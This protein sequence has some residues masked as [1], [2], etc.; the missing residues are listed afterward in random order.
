[1]H[2]SARQ[3]RV[4]QIHKENLAK[5]EKD[6]RDDPALPVSHVLQ[7]QSIIAY[8]INIGGGHVR[9]T[10]LLCITVADRN[11]SFDAKCGCIEFPMMQLN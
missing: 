3:F 1:M 7:R 5:V 2:F 6:L 9:I 4:F 10:I 11:M 8:P